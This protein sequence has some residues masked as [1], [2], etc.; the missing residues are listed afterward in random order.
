MREFMD[1][2]S[3]AARGAMHEAQF[4]YQKKVFPFR[5]KVTAAT[6]VFKI[7]TLTAN[8]HNLL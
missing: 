2:S 1:A 7:T 3:G 8:P 5:K 4:K 6:A